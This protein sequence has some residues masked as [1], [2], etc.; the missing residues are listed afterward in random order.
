MIHA[1]TFDDSHTCTLLHGFRRG[2]NNG[3]GWISGQYGNDGSGR[4]R[5]NSGY[6]HIASRRGTDTSVERNRKQQHTFSRRTNDTCSERTS[7]DRHRD[8][9][10]S[11]RRSS[12]SPDESEHLDG[13]HRNFYG[14]VGR[15]DSEHWTEW[16]HVSGNYAELERFWNHGLR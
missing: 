12:N 1:E 15:N 16:R 10:A 9:S 3:L 7:N 6:S 4:Q 5:R 2:S 14:I 8:D 11:E 13:N